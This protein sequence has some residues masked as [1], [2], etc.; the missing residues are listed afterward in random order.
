MKKTY[1][2]YY[3]GKQKMENNGT[4]EQVEQAPRN[5]NIKGRNWLL[6]WNNHKEDDL[7]WLEQYTQVNC[8]DYAYQE[9]IGEK[10][11]PHLQIFLEYHN[12]RHFNSVKE[13]FKLCHVEQCKNKLACKLYCQKKE[14][15]NGITK[16]KE[17]PKDPLKDL[18]LRDWQKEVIDL[19]T[20]EPNDRIIY[21]FFDPVGNKGK[22][23]LAKHLCIN[24]PNQVLYLS[25]KANDIKYGVANF[26][27]KNKLKLAIFDYTRSQEEYISYEA[28]ES[29][30]NGIFFNTKYESG[31]VVYDVPHVVVL[32]NFRPD[33][34]KLSAD[35]WVLKE[36]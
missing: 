36:V 26:I 24:Y 15:R 23:T 27:E 1:T 16:K 19:M 2:L 5:T 20:T 31:M 11:T 21:W 8:K 10:G 30:K 14:T 35:R 3:I 28:L 17:G 12:P 22:T 33:M 6:T 4:M 7:K 34:T 29:I 13:D 25:G 18:E 32:A 9:E